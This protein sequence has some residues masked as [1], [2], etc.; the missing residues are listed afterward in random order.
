MNL[1]DE[2]VIDNFVESLK[3]ENSIKSINRR[4]SSL[5]KFG[6]YCRTQLLT[7]KNSFENYTNLTTINSSQKISNDISLLILF[8]QYLD[9]GGIKNGSALNYLSDMRSFFIWVD[10]YF[11]K[12]GQI[13]N[14]ND[15]SSLI[16]KV[17]RELISE[18]LNEL[19]RG[20]IPTLSLNRRISTLK[21][22]GL[23]LLSQNLISEN[24]FD[25]YQK[26][27]P[28]TPQPSPAIEKNSL[29]H[30]NLF[31]TP[32]VAEIFEHPQS[33]FEPIALAYPP[34]Q[35]T[36][37]SE[38][39]NKLPLS[40]LARYSGTSP[41]KFDSLL[42][43]SAQQAGRYSAS[44]NNG[45]LFAIILILF[46]LLGPIS[47]FG[48]K[49]L[50]DSS[51]SLL[52]KASPP[53]EIK[54]VI[55]EQ[56]PTEPG[57][58]FD[59]NE[60][61]KMIKENIEGLI[62]QNAQ[63]NKFSSIDVGVTSLF[64]VNEGGVVT[65][66]T[67]NGDKITI[68]YGGTGITQI[69]Q[70]G[71]LLIGNGSSYTLSTL[72]AG[73][74]ITISNAPGK[75]TIAHKDPGSQESSDNSNGTVIQDITLDTL[76]HVTG[77]GTVDFD[78]RY[79]GLGA[80]IPVNKGGTGLGTT[81]SSGQILIGNASGGYSINTLTAGAGISIT[82]GSGS[83]TITST[84]TGT[85]TTYSANNGITL[86]SGF[87][88]LGGQLSQL[89]KIDQNS[90][91]FALWNTGNVGIGNTNPGYKLDVTGDGR[92]TTDLNVGASLSVTDN[93]NFSGLAVG[94]GTTAVFVDANGN[95]SKAG[96]GTNAFNSNTYDNY[97]SW[98]LQANGAGTTAIL[99]QNTVNFANGTGIS[100]SQTGSTITINNTSTGTTYSAN[101]GITLNGSNFFQLGGQ[102]IQPT[103]IDQNSN[104]IGFWNAGN[105]GIGLSSPTNKFV[106]Q[107]A[108][109]DSI[110]NMAIFAG[111]LNIAGTAAPITAR[112]NDIRIYDD[113]TA[114]NISD[115]QGQYVEISVRNT[116]TISTVKNYGTWGTLSGAGNISNWIHFD[117]GNISDSG[118]GTLANQYG[119]KIDDLTSATN[120]WS[121]YTG[122]AKS[123]FGGNVNVGG[124]F[125]GNTNSFIIDNAGN[126]TAGAWKG[127]ALLV[128]PMVAQD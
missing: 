116:G 66:G 28:A 118:A 69:P 9:K 70:N 34:P 16:S 103:T 83:I 62:A 92:F 23:F 46:L 78:N 49:Y 73:I 127:T 42:P 81:P 107:S 65:D 117:V 2:K 18:Y 123:H 74:G 45:R 44:R 86:A 20:Q 89:T 111:T 96:L 50:I 110:T 80:T 126:I 14:L 67:W 87:F 29:P 35:E 101:N 19:K 122:S 105:F 104:D 26:E 55:K 43:S 88:Q 109:T 61:Q 39:K 22:F 13:L 33:G 76:N 38:K 6:T 108:R 4:L 94:A 31:N 119:L 124:S 115:L 68:A 21:K 8:R 59:K 63:S 41:E 71:Q 106:V 114:G 58:E 32:L 25:I 82:N 77:I 84:G 112:G 100:M 36:V 102:L 60:I 51:K 72:T 90:N 3:K 75:I 99:Q 79:L 120:N 53:P 56:L 11:K 97:V 17:S 85:G 95:L 54:E 37:Y 91:D 40:K 5:R 113:S 27:V 30:E 1:I 7:R 93:V 98:N 57:K 128:L 121:I 12:Q 48:S 24:I 15:S 52:S 125:T 64:S 47:F 10:L